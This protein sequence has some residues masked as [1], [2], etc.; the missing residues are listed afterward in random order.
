M[1]NG[2]R[3]LKYKIGTK[4]C[5]VLLCFAL[6]ILVAFATHF[7]IGNL[8]SVDQNDTKVPNVSDISPPTIP[9]NPPTTAPLNPPT[10]APPAAEPPSTTEAATTEEIDPNIPVPN[11]VGLYSKAAFLVN[12][13]TG[14]V[15]FSYNA[16][17]RLPPAS[18]TKIMTAI[19][20]IE[21]IDDLSAT[22]TIT[23]AML[24]GLAEA[25]ASV[26]GFLPDEIVTFSDLLYGL[27]LPSGA[28]C[29]NAL[30]FEIA[31]S[32]EGFVGLMNAKA[33]ALGLTS[34]VFANTHGLH[35]P[36]LL[37]NC[38]DMAALLDYCLENETFAQIFQT[39]E[40]TTSVTQKH[41]EGIVVSNYMSKSF[42]KNPVEKVNVL[43]NK[44][45]FTTP[46]GQC[47]ASF[48]EIG[49]YEYICITLGAGK[50]GYNKE[51]YNMLDAI[52]LYTKAADMTYWVNSQ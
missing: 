37:S 24:D 30:A 22:V 46:A 13:T 51:R 42:A 16:E 43:G 28:D 15:I 20:A 32:I 17:A 2:K 18:L 25:S 6:I 41:P 8:S 48:A 5:F 47:L 49:G 26:A 34:T 19:V 3:S 27:M 29:A 40:Y 36:L 31:G 21:N 23:E 4:T 39:G 10:T 7:I 9:V 1:S 44:T 52:T 11:E 45:G 12:R 14:Q 35:D 33:A 50:A 38:K